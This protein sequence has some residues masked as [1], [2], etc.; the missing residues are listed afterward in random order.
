MLKKRIKEMEGR[1]EACSGELEK[2]RGE[3]RSA[4]NQMASDKEVKY[5]LDENMT[6]L[7]EEVKWKWG[8]R[9]RSRE[10]EQMIAEMKRS[11][12][13]AMRQKEA[14]LTVGRWGW[15]GTQETRQRLLA[16]VKGK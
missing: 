6:Q 2:T 11:F 5:Y 10:K 15:S 16:A 1:L 3:L 9:M 7:G 13:E 12:A 8:K 14:V 4:Y